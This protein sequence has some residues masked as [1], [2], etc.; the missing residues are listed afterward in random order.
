M[1]IKHNME[2]QHFKQGE[3]RAALCIYSSIPAHNQAKKGR[4][5]VWNTK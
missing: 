1:A 5:I 4:I 2:T 3:V